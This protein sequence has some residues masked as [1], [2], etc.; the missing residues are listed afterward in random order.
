MT[1]SKNTNNPRLEIL[2][3]VKNMFFINDLKQLR[4]KIN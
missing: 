4:T 1:I 2:T 3:N